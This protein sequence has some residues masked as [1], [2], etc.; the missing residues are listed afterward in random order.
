[1]APR[2]QRV[3]RSPAS[4]TAGTKSPR[5]YLHLLRYVS[6]LDFVVSVFRLPSSLYR[7]VPAT[8]EIHAVNR[9]TDPATVY[10]VR[11][12]QDEPDAEYR[13]AVIGIDPV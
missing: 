6:S 11:V 2:S 9:S 5:H 10:L 12:P 1:M 4:S 13:A 7:T 3:S 8:V